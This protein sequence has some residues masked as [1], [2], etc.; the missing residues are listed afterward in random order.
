MKLTFHKNKILYFPKAFVCFL[1][2]GLLSPLSAIAEWKEDGRK[3]GRTNYNSKFLSSSDDI[4]LHFESDGYPQFIDG[5]HIINYHLQVNDE[6]QVFDGDDKFFYNQIVFEDVLLCG[7]ENVRYYVKAMYYYY[8]EYKPSPDNLLLDSVFHYDFS[9]QGA[10]VINDKLFVAA[11]NGYYRQTCDKYGSQFDSEFIIGLTHPKRD[12]NGWDDWIDYFKN[13]NN[14][15][16]VSFDE[17][18]SYR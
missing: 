2:V 16:K 15:K 7:E 3:D 17:W 10:Q 18:L 9:N 12:G 13:A 14:Y 8:Q 4:W 1:L 5:T 11:S 6:P